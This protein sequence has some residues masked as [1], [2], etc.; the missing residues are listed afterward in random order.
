MFDLSIIISTYQNVEYLQ[1]CFD[2]IINSIKDKNVE[3]LVGIDACL[4]TYDFIKTN[5]SPPY[6]KFFFFEKNQGPYVVFNTLVL[7]SKSE[8]VL[9]F[10]S[11]DIMCENMVD[12]LI[13]ESKS[14][15]IVKPSYIDFKNG[16]PIN[17][18]SK[19]IQSEG[20]FLINKEIFLYI[21]GFE[22]WLCAADTDFSIR[23]LKSGHKFRFTNK[24]SFYRR[25]HDKQLTAKKDTGPH[26]DLRSKY[27]N[28]ITQK[29]DKFK[30]ETLVTYPFV[31]LNEVDIKKVQSVHDVLIEK[32][33]TR[34]FLKKIILD[35]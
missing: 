9:F 2:S 7:E 4:D 17:E 30:N 29:G 21:N 32:T 18:N 26:S 12:H 14:H 24:L 8:N 23:L 27:A 19:K 34:N 16:E 28:M 20:V 31:S 6:F 3:V 25:L 33:N 1:E 13:E 11:D 35:L 22:P 10:G 5:S 15:K